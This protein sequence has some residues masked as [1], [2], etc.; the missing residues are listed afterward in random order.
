MISKNKPEIY[1]NVILGKGVVIEPF[2]TI[3][4]PPR[5]KRAGELKTVIADNTLIRAGTTIYAGVKLGKGF[6]SG[7]NVLIR[8]GNIIGNNVSIGSNSML[9]PGNKIGNRVR[10]HSGCFLESVTIEDDCFIGPCVVFTDDLH[11]PCP[12]YKDC[13]GGA[14]VKSNVK[15]GANS[16]IL[17]GVV[18]G[19][20]ALVGAGSLV[21]E[22][23]SKN[24][25]VTGCPAKK[26]KSVAALKCFKGFFKRPYIWEA[27]IR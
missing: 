7:H 14:I 25:V 15:I 26:I 11:P 19:K 2:C 9:E 21:A 23:V 4:K 17:P 20:N 18:I 10:I 13:K 6:Q 3:G 27:K 5:G 24:T 12:R 16:T 22:D 1:P 8:E